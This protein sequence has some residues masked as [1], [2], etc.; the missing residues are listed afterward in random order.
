MKMLGK[1]LRSNR[2][3]SVSHIGTRNALHDELVDLDLVFFGTDLER[4]SRMKVAKYFFVY[5]G[6][7]VSRFLVFK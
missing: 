4:I 1:A 5:P 3:L 6:D 2:D 7:E